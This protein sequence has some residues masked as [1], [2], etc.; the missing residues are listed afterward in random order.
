MIMVDIHVMAHDGGGDA[1]HIWV[2]LGEDVEAIL[3]ELG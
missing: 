2:I 1:Y 3:Q